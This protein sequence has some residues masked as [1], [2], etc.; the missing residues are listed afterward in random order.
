[1]QTLFSCC[2]YKSVTQFSYPR[3]NCTTANPTFTQPCYT[4]I[5]D[6]LTNSLST[7]ALGGVVIGVIE[8]LGLILSVGMF[9]RLAIRKHEQDQLLAESWRV[10]K[11]KIQHGYQNYQVRVGECV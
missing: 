9:R 2:G 4:K 11:D 8:L 6:S 1:M 10:N 7:I 5:Y 3:E